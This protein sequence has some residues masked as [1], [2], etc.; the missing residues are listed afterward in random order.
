MEPIEPGDIIEPTLAEAARVLSEMKKTK[1]LDKRKTQSEILKNLCDSA[2]VF[3]GFMSD[4]LM[5]D[6]LPD[7]EDMELFEDFEVEEEH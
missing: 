3:F 6:A 5:A 1:D 7:P 2:G 4:A